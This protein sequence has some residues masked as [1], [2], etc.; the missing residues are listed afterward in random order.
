[1][2]RI[3]GEELMAE[4]TNKNYSLHKGDNF[5]RVKK[6][7]KQGNFEI[8]ILFFDEDEILEITKKLKNRSKKKNNIWGVLK[9][10]VFA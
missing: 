2:Q 6:I 5:I 1:M 4:R 7:Q 9:E 10:K 8:R 3:K